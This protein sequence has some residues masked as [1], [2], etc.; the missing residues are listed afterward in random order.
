MIFLCFWWFF[1]P[2]QFMFRVFQFS[3]KALFFGL[4]DENIFFRSGLQ[5]SRHTRNKKEKTNDGGYFDGLLGVFREREQPDGG[6]KGKYCIYTRRA[7]FFFFVCESLLLVL[8][9]SF[10]FIV[11]LRARAQERERERFSL[12]FSFFPPNRKK[13]ICARSSLGRARARARWMVFTRDVLSHPL[14]HEMRAFVES[15][16]AVHR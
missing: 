5:F 7:S 13:K 14:S 10:W 4:V 9:L 12:G 3:R 6:T 16:S 11:S 1:F 2:T 8:L 15:L